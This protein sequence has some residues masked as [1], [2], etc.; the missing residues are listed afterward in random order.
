MPVYKKEHFKLKQQQ[1]QRS[2]DR[3]I[4]D[5]CQNIKTRV[6]GTEG[7][8]RRLEGKNIEKLA[9]GWIT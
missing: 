4:F 1:V 9:N 6:I 3:S 7:E 8:I 5:M 2:Y